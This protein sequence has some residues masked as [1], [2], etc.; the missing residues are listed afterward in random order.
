MQRRLPF[1]F[2]ILLLSACSTPP[3]SKEKTSPIKAANED[4]LF[5]NLSMD[6]IANP[7]TQAEKDRNII[8]SYAMDNTLEVQK[9]NLGIYYQILKEGE[10]RNPTFSSKI[11]AH[12]EGKLLNGKIF[13]SSYERGEPLQFA[14][15]RVIPGWQEAL[16]M[17]KPGGKGIF[18]IPSRMAY[19]PQG[20]GKMIPPDEVL[21]FQIELIGFK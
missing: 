5:A 14:M 17:L 9:T 20:F 10:G 15:G 12:Y 21:W 6:L 3:D 11:T 19:G 13:D 1:L 8:V 7:R 18:L 2:L 4:D 16:T